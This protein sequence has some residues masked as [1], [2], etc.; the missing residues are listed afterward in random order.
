MSELTTDQER[1]IARFLGYEIVHMPLHRKVHVYAD[2]G[3]ALLFDPVKDND[4]NH[5]VLNALVIE[6]C[7]KDWEMVNSS[8]GFFGGYY[9]RIKTVHVFKY[10]KFNNENVCRALIAVLDHK[11]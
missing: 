11:I 1:K 10:D 5:K 3:P 8:I 9:E 7:K 6:C 4:I 2:T